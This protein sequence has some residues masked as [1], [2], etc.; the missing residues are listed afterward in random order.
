MAILTYQAHAKINLYLH[1]IGKRGDGYHLLDSCIAFTKL[2]DT[3]IVEPSNTLS[4]NVSGAFSSSLFEIAEDDNLILR[5]AR[6]LA[7]TTG[8]RAGA[9]LSLVKRLPVA[10]GLGGGSADAAATLNSLIKFWKVDVR[11]INLPELALSLGADVPACLTTRPPFVGGIGEQIFPA[12]NLPRAG[13]LLINPR[14]PLATGDVF[15]GYSASYSNEARFTANPSNVSELSALLVRRR[16]DLTD[17]VL[18]LCPVVGEILEV[19]ATTPGCHLA[20][21]TGS[22]ATCFGLFDNLN[23][24]AKAAK[25]L[26]CDKWWIMPTD[27]VSY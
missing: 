13:L 19:L 11:K 22:G 8:I 7:D 26:E 25:V 12:P 18:R 20:R 2:C 14:E 10:A 4:L 3:L 23:A 5:A 17:I 6:L 15:A 16:N 21:M 1:I 24:A 27:I 9:S